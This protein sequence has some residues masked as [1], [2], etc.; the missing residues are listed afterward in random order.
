MNNSFRQLVFENR[1]SNH[2]YPMNI[3]NQYGLKFLNENEPR[4]AICILKIG[5]NYF[6]SVL[7][8][9]IHN[10]K[11]ILHQLVEIN[12]LGIY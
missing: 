10:G 11:L 4:F 12:F 8:L 7:E 6:L 3:W 5:W 1:T 2:T 9:D